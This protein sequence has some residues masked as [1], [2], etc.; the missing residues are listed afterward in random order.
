MIGDKLNKLRMLPSA[1]CT[2]E[3]FLR[4]VTI[5]ITGSLPTVEEYEAFM[6]DASADKRAKVIDRLLE[7]KEFAEIWAMKWSEWL[8]VKSTNQVSYKSMY[9]YSTWLS[10]NIA[11]NVPLDK[12]FAARLPKEQRPAFEKLVDAVRASRG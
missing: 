11:R 7:R 6:A 8:M 4:S 5:D 3:E 9:L 2:D 10:D 12:R 1:I